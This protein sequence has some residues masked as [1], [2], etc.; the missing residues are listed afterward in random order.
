MLQVPAP[1]TAPL[2]PNTEP[3]MGYSPS[4]SHAMPQSTTAIP[5][6]FQPPM[7]QPRP[8]QSRGTPRSSLSGQGSPSISPLKHMTDSSNYPPQDASMSPAS[9]TPTNA[10]NLPIS[11][12][13]PPTVYSSL[14]P[15]FSS[16]APAISRSNSRGSDAS[17]SDSSLAIQSKEDL[18]ALSHV[19]K[20]LRG[21]GYSSQKGS[22]VEFITGEAPVVPVL[23]YLEHAKAGAW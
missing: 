8:P 23:D 5:S 12:V 4:S 21:N 1:Y 2:P 16:R 17:A 14:A 3:Y 10:T 11:N 15:E 18:Q 9:M 20:L 6:V 7:H 22:L 13:S 19:R